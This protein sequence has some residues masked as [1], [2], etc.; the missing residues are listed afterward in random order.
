MR[1][2]SL[3][4]LEEDTVT[5]LMIRTLKSLHPLLPSTVKK[6]NFGKFHFNFDGNGV[7]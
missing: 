4:T 5:N 2:P 3:F 1:K 6:V 7:K